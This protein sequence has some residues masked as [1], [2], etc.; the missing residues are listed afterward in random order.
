MENALPITLLFLA[1]I[2]L[3]VVDIF[4]P[5]HGVLTLASLCLLGYGLYLCYQI[6][7]TAAL[8]ALAGIAVVVPTLLYIAVRTWHRTAIGRKI[9]PPNPVLSDE[10]RLP[11]AELEAMIGSQGRA[12]TQLRPVGTCVFDGKRVEA[13][14]EHGMISPNMVVEAVGLSGRTV[15]VR[16]MQET[17]EGTT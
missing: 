7:E 4:L 11:L 14:A 12:L 13:M 8:G 3:L 10:D 5:S 17:R 6:S 1:G 15:I 2:A 16:P 9:A